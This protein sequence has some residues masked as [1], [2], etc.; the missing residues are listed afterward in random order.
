MPT[1][2]TGLSGN[3]P[4]TEQPEISAVGESVEV[5]G[6]RMERVDLRNELHQTMRTGGH[7]DPN[8][9][10]MNPGPRGP[11]IEAKDAVGHAVPEF[12]QEEESSPPAGISPEQS[13]MANLL[14][15][16]IV[17]A[18]SDGR[19]EAA[20][21]LKDM[22]GK[23]MGEMEPKRLR[24][25]RETHPA[26]LKLRRNLGLQKIPPVTIEWC[27]T[28]WHFAPPPPALDRW[29]AD[30][31]ESGLGSYSALKLA[32]AVIGLDGAP[33]YNVFGVELRAS[34]APPD[35]SATVE[36]RLY[37]KRCDA[38]NEIIEVDAQKCEA[39]GSLH[40][41]FE[42]PLNLR[43]RCAELMHRH[44]S[45]EFGPYEDLRHLHLKMRDKM[46]DRMVDKATLY[47][48]P[49]LLLTSSSETDT[50]PTGDEQSSD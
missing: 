40:D 29:V 21:E 6:R 19:E 5:A 10:P 41:P 50:T 27:N 17:E 12:L 15:Q 3:Q 34:Y 1:Q 46:A 39:C 48:F 28:K 14:A 26:L 35:G 8:A 32:A 20:G 49:E 47:P 43:V 30:M 24:V 38:C 18:Q 2:R 22:L 36:V 31:T 37:E 45:E 11:S 13:Q 16:R 7:Q 23:M 33:L 4:P 25:Q 44:F 9:T 42:M